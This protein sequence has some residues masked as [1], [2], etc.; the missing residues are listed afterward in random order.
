MTYEDRACQG[1]QKQTERVNSCHLILFELSDHPITHQTKQKTTMSTSLATH[2]IGT[3]ATG[4]PGASQHLRPVRPGFAGLA[5]ER[6]SSRWMARKRERKRLKGE[7]PETPFLLISCSTCAP[8]SVTRVPTIC[9]TLGRT[10][11]PLL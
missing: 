10:R 9:L 7:T 5:S 8:A 11:H 6:A 2:G 1:S 3:S 4:L